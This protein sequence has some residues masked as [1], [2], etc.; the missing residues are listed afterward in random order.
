MAD[1]SGR[2]AKLWLRAF[3]VSGLGRAG[4]AA[5]F[6][7]GMKSLAMLVILAE[8]APKPVT[9]E[10]LVELLWERV[11]PAQGKG[12]LRQEIRRIKKIVGDDL[13]D[14]MLDVADAHVA[15]R[16]G[17]V[18]YDAAAA[19]AAAESDDADEI[20]KLMTLCDGD[21]LASNTARA[22]SFQQWALE[23]REFLKDMT[24]A[25]LA[26]LGFMDLE[27]GRVER[28]QTAADRVAQIDPLHEKGHEVMIRAHLASGRR[29]QARA[30]FE[31]FRAYLLRELATEPDK[32]LA[33]LVAPGP[34]FDAAA[35]P[36]KKE[37]A[38]KRPSAAAKRN[39]DR[40]M[41][42][43]MNVTR[44]G[45]NDQAYLADGV[46]EQLVANLSRSAWIRV[47][48]LN[49][50]PYPVLESDIDRSQRDLRGFADYVLRVDVRS[51]GGNVAITATL[52]RIE[53]NATVFSDRME[54]R[55]DDILA[56]QRDVALRIASI[57]EPIVV[58]AEAKREAGIVW[59]GEPQNVD[60]WR[61]VMRARWLFWK[62][63]PKTNAEARALLERAHEISPEDSP[64]IC[65]LAFTHMLDAWSDWTPEVDWS[66]AEAKRW[67]QKAVNV[68]PNDA[69]AQFTLGVMCSTHDG[70][71]QA[72]A[73]MT[74][75]LR[76][77]PS[78][79]IAHGELAR[80]HV[81]CGETEKALRLA[82]EALALSP[83]D[84]QSGLWIRTK[85]IA[86]WIDGDLEQALELIDYGLVVR[87]GW[88]QNH[89][90]RAAI[91]AEMG[92]TAEAR[93]AFDEA[94]AKVGAYSEAALRIG[95]PFSDAAL[96]KRFAS[97]LNKAGGAYA[98]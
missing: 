97:A 58:E 86:F 25:A 76:L 63:T 91:L 20:A 1:A 26:R 12:S 79:I 80:F 61:L 24:V 98:T 30:H 74:H 34:D 88:F 48:A 54:N 69:W 65:L 45:D 71:E 55:L 52:N 6:P 77:S 44:G 13:F 60:H 43:V 4:E 29:G 72:K 21:F 68:S 81:F 42:A 37:A 62:L 92:R 16:S 67:A 59:D 19:V 64:T 8:A 56:L 3:G 82:D 84:Q 18:D 87:P 32:G 17:V 70:I 50:A 36:A 2:K 11:E 23:R 95:H 5:A 40:P 51:G 41:I 10:Q 38:S 73:R 75:A 89:V 66:V 46:A 83:Y 7:L 33:A 93:Q 9:R 22:E 47:A 57:F 31:R 28:A 15:M 78:L 39:G 35:A 49:L 27:A 85:A 96:H 90:L 94:R 53:D 14:A